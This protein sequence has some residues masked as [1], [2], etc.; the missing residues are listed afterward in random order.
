MS[1]RLWN[2]G[3]GRGDQF[4]KTVFN[5]QNQAYFKYRAEFRPL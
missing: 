1:G 4:R 5:V 3:R 2:N